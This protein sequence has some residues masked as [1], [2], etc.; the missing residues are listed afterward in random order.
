MRFHFLHPGFISAFLCAGAFAFSQP[1]QS[2][3]AKLIALGRSD[4]Q[5]MEH[6]DHIVNRIGPRLTGSDNLQNACEWARAEFESYGLKN[7]RLEQWGEFPVGFNRGPSS[8]HMIEPEM[9]ELHFGTSAWSAGTHGP[10][11]GPALIAPTDE[12]QLEK[13]RPKL[14][15]AW[16]LVPS[17]AA[18][19]GARGGPP[20]A[21][22]AGASSGAGTS[23][24]SA[25]E[26]S[27]PAPGAASPASS[28]RAFRDSLQKRRC[29]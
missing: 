11:R 23:G 18:R 1:Q 29:G 26:A 3:A 22:N 19:G 17:T 25:R 10:T 4:N 9:M 21:A 2:D 14:K 8:G 16:I 12:A 20:P 24:A 6:L 15:G 5:V 13:L 27:A 28:D 7:C